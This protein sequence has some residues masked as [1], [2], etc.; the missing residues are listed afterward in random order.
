[1]SG[2]LQAVFQN[3]RS[4]FTQPSIGEAYG[5]G[6]FAG[7]INQGG[8]IYNLVI[9]PKSGGE[10]AAKWKTSNTEDSGCDSFIDG[11]ANT[12]AID[13]S[14]HPA[15]QFCNALTIGGFT[16]W[17]MPAKNELEVC[18]YYLKPSTT[19]NNTSS[20]SNA[21]AVSP[22]PISTNYSS[23]SPAQTSVTAFQT[24]GSEVFIAARYSSSTQ[25]SVD[26]SRGWSHTFS[27]GFQ[28]V[29][30]DKNTSSNV[31]AVRRVAVQELI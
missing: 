5:G 7:Q 13:D 24:G 2:A 9:A 11:P 29:S 31:R 27:D 23:G 8:T 19:T 10:T 6:F 12:N 17:Y 1:M 15:A 22:E 26:T 18:Y 30:P 28:G 3:Q 14:L 20:G 25:Y 21:N 4:F 16:D